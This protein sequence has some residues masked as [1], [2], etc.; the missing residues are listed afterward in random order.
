MASHRWKTNRI[1]TLEIDGQPNTNLRDI[2]KHVVYYYKNILGTE[3]L[4]FGFMNSNFWPVDSQLTAMENS[5]VILPFKDFEIKAAIFDSSSS[6][7]LAQM[8][9]PSCFIN[10]FG[11]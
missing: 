3:G 11:N 8:D 5:Q 6:G 2:K 1:N 9:F 4:K 7:A 10:P